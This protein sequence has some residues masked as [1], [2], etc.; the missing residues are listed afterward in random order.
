MRT[1]VL[2][3]FALGLKAPALAAVVPRAEEKNGGLEVEFSHLVGSS[4]KAAMTNIGSESLKLLDYDT[5]LDKNA[6]HK[7]SIVKDGQ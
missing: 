4:I 6:V 5:L 3:L 1:F 7:L 2:I